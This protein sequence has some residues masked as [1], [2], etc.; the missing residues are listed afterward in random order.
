MNSDSLFAPTHQGMV[1]AFYGAKLGRLPTPYEARERLVEEI[2]ELDEA[3]ALDIA[4]EVT[5]KELADVLYTAYGYACAMGWNLHGAF[6]RVHV[7]NMTKA[8]ATTGKVPKG[9]AYVPPD[10]GG[11]V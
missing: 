3:L 5:L 4:P 2:R 7:S 9:A 10:L 1:A 11:Y 6:E 8:H